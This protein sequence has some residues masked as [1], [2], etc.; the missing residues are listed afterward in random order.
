MPSNPYDLSRGN[1]H[2]VCVNVGLTCTFRV[3]ENYSEAKTQ[4]PAGVCPRC[5]APVRVEEPYTGRILPMHIDIDP[6]SRTYRQVV[7][8]QPALEEVP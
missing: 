5:G 6:R 4:F 7:P 3:N 8:N 2:V 1:Y